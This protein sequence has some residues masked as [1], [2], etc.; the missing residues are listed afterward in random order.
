MS[1]IDAWA[2]D[3]AAGKA[4]EFPV[5]VINDLDKDWQ[6]TIR[7]RLLH[8]GVAIFEKSQDCKVESLGK[9][10]LGFTLNLPKKPGKYQVEAALLHADN[11]PVRSLRD[12]QL[13]EKTESPP[14]KPSIDEP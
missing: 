4:Q 8:E 12:F 3:Y 11:E 2:E 5:V 1:E 9:T 14:G 10:N 13:K 6:G 7:C